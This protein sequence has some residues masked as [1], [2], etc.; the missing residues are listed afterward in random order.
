MPRKRAANATA[1]YRSMHVASSPARLLD[2]LYRQLLTD[3][4]NAERF[5]E[6]REPAKKAEAINRGLAILGELEAALDRERAPELCANL[7]RLYG[8]VRERLL[9]ASASL[10]PKPI[11]EAKRVI[12]T[13]RES[14]ARASGVTT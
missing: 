2:G 9:S 6:R 13:L 14:F 4:S 8:F 3:L 12:L 7:S 11:D 1:T 5:I 10:N